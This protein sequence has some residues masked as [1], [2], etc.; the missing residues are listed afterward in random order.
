MNKYFVRVFYSASILLNVILLGKMNQT[1][2]AR[3]YELKQAGMWHMCP[4]I[5]YFFPTEDH[6]MKSWAKWETRRRAIENAKLM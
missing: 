3:N 4:V 2:S 5:D 6:C 1:F